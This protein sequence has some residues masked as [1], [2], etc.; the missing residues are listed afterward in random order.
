MLQ[1]EAI[2]NESKSPAE[3][4]DENVN[5]VEDYV[6]SLG[7]S[8]QVASAIIDVIGDMESVHFTRGGTNRNFLLDVAKEKYDTYLAEEPK[9]RRFYA[10]EMAMYLGVVAGGLKTGDIAVTI[11]ALIGLILTVLRKLSHNSCDYDTAITV[12]DSDR[13]KCEYF[14]SF[15]GIP[16][17]TFL[18]FY[19][20]FACSYQTASDT[21]LA[22]LLAS[23]MMVPEIILV[24]G[25][26]AVMFIY[27]CGLTLLKL[28]SVII[29]AFVRFVRFIISLVRAKANAENIRMAVAMIIIAAL[30]FGAIVLAS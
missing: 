23:H 27:A 30:V 19:F 22:K 4:L 8:K 24:A 25:I 18:M 26:P 16:L 21:Q 28:P 14:I 20:A 17:M 29:H 5:A 15:A 3:I 1:G 12:V 13:R 7:G 2:S 9:L 11:G 10:I 6:V